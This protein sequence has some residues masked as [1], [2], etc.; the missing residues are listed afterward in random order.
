MTFNAIHKSYENYD[1]YTFKQ[2]EVPMDKPICLGF[3][4]LELSKLLMYEAYYNKLQPDFK[5]KII[6]LHYMDTDSLVLSVNTKD[7]I[8]DLK[9]LDNLIDFSNLNEN[10]EIFSKRINKQLLDLKVKLIKLFGLTILFV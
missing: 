5:Q 8:T 7:M 4:V 1:S 3:S 2:N 10:H 6:L 9:N